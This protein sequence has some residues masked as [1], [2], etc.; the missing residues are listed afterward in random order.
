MNILKQNLDFLAEFG[1]KPE[2]FLITS[3]RYNCFFSILEA[4]E[5]YPF[6]AAWKVLK[7]WQ[8]HSSQFLSS[9]SELWLVWARVTPG[10]WLSMAQNTVTKV[11]EDS[12]WI[13]VPV[14]VVHG[15]WTC[16]LI[17]NL[18]SY[19]YRLFLHCCSS[20]MEEQE[21]WKKSITTSESRTKNRWQKTTVEGRSRL[22]QGTWGSVRRLEMG[23]RV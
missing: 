5:R 19:S 13:S 6:T 8:T 9:N 16:E 23:K 11:K 1:F 17:N 7:V 3:Q 2:V 22:G 18:F 10:K 15:M 21:I 12:S 20:D 14:N 4:T